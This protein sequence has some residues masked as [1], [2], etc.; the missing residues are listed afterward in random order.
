[1]AG[2][3]STTSLLA[4]D[5]SM[6]RADGDRWSALAGLVQ[7]QHLEP[8]SVES[9]RSAFELHPARFFVIEDFLVPEVAERLSE[10]L[11][12]EASFETE[13][14]LYSVDG[15]KVDGDQWSAAPEEDRFFRYGRLVGT[16]SQYQFSPN[17]L[18]YLRFRS[19]FQSDDD[20]RSF[21]EALTG[22]ELARSDDFGSHSMGAGDFLK[23]HDDSDRNRRLAL[24]LYLSPDWKADLGGSLHIVLPD[25]G[26]WMVEPEFNSL[27]AF[28]TLAGTMHFVEIVRKAA[29]EERRVTIGG[30][31]HSP[32]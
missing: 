9:R 27:V 3:A 20:L 17:S 22:L 26:T 15:H 4:Y 8:A 5:P 13:Y 29:G 7:P 21:F 18:A 28:D 32:E 12:R 14:G 25:G 6:A 30:W 19:V 10:F 2:L 16:P 31:Y 1:M 23:E 24:V 11:R